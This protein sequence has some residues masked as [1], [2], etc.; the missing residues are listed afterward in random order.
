MRKP[1][2]PEQKAERK[3]YLREYYVKNI[4]EERIKRK[5]YRDNNK[6][7]TRMRNKLYRDKNKTEI[8]KKERD[9]YLNNKAEILARQKKYREDNSIIIAKKVKITGVLY[10]QNNKGKI[11]KLADAWR[12][13]KPHYSK[14]YMKK[15]RATDE[16][17]RL[18]CDISRLI[19]NSFKNKGFKKNAKTIDILGCDNLEFKQYIESKFEAWMNWDNYGNPKDGV[20]ELNK[21][22]DLD[23]II[24]LITATSEAD[25]IRLN[26]YSNFQPLCS[27][28]NRIIKRNKLKNEPILR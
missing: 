13:L 18:K 19:R 3:I 2:T 15:R 17:F 23:H 1:L 25:I 24:P 22:W 28:Y 11:K 12:K 26:H 10:R 5:N 16:L 21:T 14:E 8:A 6:E 4:V 27:Y 9:F 20:L 7:K